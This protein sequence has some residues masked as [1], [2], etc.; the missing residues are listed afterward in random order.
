LFHSFFIAIDVY[1]HT[2]LQGYIGLHDHDGCAAN[3]TDW[4][5]RPPR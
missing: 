3:R 2:G 5:G 1:N 4:H